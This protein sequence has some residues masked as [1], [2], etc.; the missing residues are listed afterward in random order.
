MHCLRLCASCSRCVF[1]PL[2]Q[3]HGDCSWFS[4]AV[5]CA[6]SKLLNDV[7][8]FTSGPAINASGWPTVSAD[9]GGY[10]SGGAQK[11]LLKPGSRFQSLAERNAHARRAFVFGDGAIWLQHVRKAGGTSLCRSISDAMRPSPPSHAA[12]VKHCTTLH[13]D[14]ASVDGA[15]Q[16]W[17]RGSRLWESEKGGFPLAARRGIVDDS[18]SSWVFVTCLRNPINLLISTALY[19]VDFKLL[20]RQPADANSA[21]EATQS[22]VNVSAL[23]ETLLL[24]AVGKSSEP[25]L[26]GCRYDNY[27]TRVFSSNCLDDALVSAQDLQEAQA[28][29]AAFELVFVLEWLPEM[30][31][32][33][34]YFLGLDVFGG[35]LRNRNSK[36][37][38]FQYRTAATRLSRAEL[39]SRKVASSDEL[40]ALLPRAT[41]L[42]LKELLRHDF[43]LYE[44]AKRRARDMA[45]TMLFKEDTASR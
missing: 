39:I 11:L 15:L 13:T 28:T 8:G 3:V 35:E 45:S 19:D 27:M 14:Y 4:A 40:Q 33:A 5:Q 21:T 10:R 25:V 29:L 43:V 31:P 16:A 12:A 6:P 22:A 41:V 17:A 26:H 34:R 20:I 44:E 18:L 2:S 36:H 37:E 9:G 1:V 42:R 7:R 23:S 30:L 38:P 24:I 32:L